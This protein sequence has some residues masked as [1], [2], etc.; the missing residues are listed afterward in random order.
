MS[1]DEQYNEIEM[2]ISNIEDYRRILE[3]L[4]RYD[5]EDFVK[6]ETSLFNEEIKK[7]QYL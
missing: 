4:I 6:M 3:T 5:N 2:I 7:F 1:L